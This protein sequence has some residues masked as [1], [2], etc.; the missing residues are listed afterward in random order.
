MQRN[1][2][3]KISS[4]LLALMAFFFLTSC[5]KTEPT[6]ATAKKPILTLHLTSPTFTE[7]SPMPVKHTCDGEDI[8]PPLQ[9]S[10]GPEETRGFA[11][12]MDDPDAPGGTFVHWVLYDLPA[13][14]AS[15]LE[16]IPARQTLDNGAK[17][18]TNS[19]GRIGYAGPCPPSG[20][21]HR[22]IF[23]LY[24]LDASLPLPPGTTNRE[25][26]NAMKGHILAEGQLMG[27]YKRK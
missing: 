3:I 13:Q 9:W 11:L 18:G 24:A 2:K 19:F 25:L 20:E 10:P 6:N 12:I 23:K 1:F 4:G 15:L 14:A 22:Y 21:Q 5:R 16:R 27:I 26:L 17:Q 8:S 7:G